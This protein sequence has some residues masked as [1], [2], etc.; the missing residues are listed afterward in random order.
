MLSYPE[1]NSIAQLYPGPQVLL[2]KVIHWTEKRDGSNLRIALVDNR[3]QVSTRHMEDA[4]RQF[5]DYFW[6]TPQAKAVE[7]LIRWHSG[8]ADSSVNDFNFQPVVFG[9]LLVKGKSPARFETHDKHEFILFDIWDSKA[10][11]FLNYTALY[12]HAYHFGLPVVASW[13]I[14]RH[15]TLEDLYAERDALL[16]VA[17]ERGREGVVL[18]AFDGQQH[19]YAKEKLDTPKIERVRVNDGS[20]MLPALPESELRGAV[21]KAHADLG[22]AFGDKTIAMPLI[23]KYVA[24]E[25]RKH[26]CS[27][28][29]GNLYSFYCEYLEG[30]NG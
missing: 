13:C 23:A 26:M 1:L 3:I 27:K 9:E 11:R 18:K 16:A 7:E 5:Q 2:G 10:E 19:L 30:I 21:A 29:Y 8:E 14:S 24:E 4:S 12:Q 20:P 22:E 6:A 15:L 25:V 17:K 28:P